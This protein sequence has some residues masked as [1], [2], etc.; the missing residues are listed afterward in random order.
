M[1]SVKSVVGLIAALLPVGY[2][3][4]FLYYFVDVSGDSGPAA[5]GLGPTVLGLGIV[6]LLFCIPLVLKLMRLAS[7]PRA[8]APG[9]GEREMP[10]ESTF[11]ADAAL[12]RYMARKATG[13]VEAPVPPRDAAP[14][15]TFGRR[16]V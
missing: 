13:A 4:Y 5:M 15:A 3:G 12:A 11:D 2:C 16:V 6:G 10:A 1:G 8:P 7:G 14:R 9:G